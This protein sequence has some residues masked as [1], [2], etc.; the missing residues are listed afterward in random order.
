MTEA[1]VVQFANLLLEEAKRFLERAEKAKDKDKA[2]E[3]ANLHA[4]LMLAFCAL[5]AHVN[6]VAD[7]VARWEH[8]TKHQR[9]V[10]LQK[11]V[12]LNDGEFEV[13]NKS[14]FSRVQDRILLLHRIGR[15]AIK[16][17]PWSQN[18]SAAIDLRNK[19]THPKA[20]PAITAAAVSKA[21]EAVI[22]TLDALYQALYKRRF[23]AAHRKLASKLDF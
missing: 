14:E 1:N 16:P 4:A 15:G 19:L 23:P 22:E 18:L 7:E 21:V 8:V 5:D 20:V 9:G 10:L 3:V 17:A 12:R 6:V 2:A 13:G 11:E